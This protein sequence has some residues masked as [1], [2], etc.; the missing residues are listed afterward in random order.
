MAAKTTS[1]TIHTLD[2][3]PMVLKRQTKK[4]LCLLRQNYEIQTS[5]YY[6]SH[7]PTKLMTIERRE[8]KAHGLMEVRLNE[9]FETVEVQVGV[10]ER[11]TRRNEEFHD[12]KV[13]L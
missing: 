12:E 10:L 6:K 7:C 5:K 4:K 13:F 8:R 9:E 3:V 1:T 11:A 2:L